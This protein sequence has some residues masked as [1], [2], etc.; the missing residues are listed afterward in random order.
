[1]GKDVHVSR[2][3]FYHDASLD[4]ES[5][6]YHVV[7]SE[8]GIPVQRLMGLVETD[9]GLKFQVRWS[10]LSQSDDTLDHLVRVYEDLPNLFEKLLKRKNTPAE[11][12]NKARTVLRL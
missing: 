6:M 9:D 8:T 11:H 1:M 12:V 3:K 5:I 7:S 10:C 2:M 4:I